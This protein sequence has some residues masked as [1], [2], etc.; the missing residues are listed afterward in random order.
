MV[1]MVFVYSPAMLIVIEDH[2]TW[3]AFLGTVLSCAIGVF[4]VAT[5]VAGFFLAHMGP[6]A[7]TAMALAGVLLVA[8]GAESDMYALVMFAPVF[9]HQ[10]FRWRRN[11]AD[12][13]VQAA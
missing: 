4:L 8:P 1:P 7:R 2:F 9:I 11:R 13:A 12:L 10:L 3:G 5:S 6:P